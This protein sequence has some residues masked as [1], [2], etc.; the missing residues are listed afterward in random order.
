MLIQFNEIF[1]VVWILKGL[2]TF[3]SEDNVCSWEK[4]HSFGY[5]LMFVMLTLGF[6]LILKWTFKMLEIL[7]VVFAALKRFVVARWYR[8][9]LRLRGRRETVRVNNNEEL[10]F[11]FMNPNPPR[12]REEVSLMT[13]VGVPLRPD[14]YAVETILYSH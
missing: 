10:M 8:L 14:V 2:K 11:S 4:S 13:R 12:A 5:I 3:Y 1:E 9:L 7:L 6:I